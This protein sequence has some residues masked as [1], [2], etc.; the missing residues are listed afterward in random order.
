MSGSL[1]PSSGVNPQIAL[2]GQPVRSNPLAI[3]QQAAGAVG[4]MSQAQQAQ[5]TLQAQRQ[6]GNATLG[7][8]GEDGRFDQQRFLQSIRDNPMAGFLAPQALQQAR[9]AELGQ[10]QVAQGQVQVGMMRLNSLSQVVT[11]L[12]ENPNVSRRDVIDSVGRLLALPESERP[13]SATIAAGFLSNLPEDSAG[14]RQRLM[15]IAGSVRENQARLNDFL[16]RPQVLNFGNEQ[17]TIDLNPRTGQ[18]VVGPQGENF[19][20]PEFTNQPVQ[21]VGPQGETRVGPLQRTLPITGGLGTPVPSQAPAGQPPSGPSGAGRSPPTTGPRVNDI[22][23]SGR[24]PGG[25]GGTQPGPRVPSGGVGPSADGTV[26]TSLPPGRSQAMQAEA[27]RGQEMASVLSQAAAAAPN[28]IANL[29]TMRGLLRQFPTGGPVA[30][31]LRQLT[32]SMNAMLP[33]NLRVRPS[34]TAYQ[35]E[36]V[37]L[38]ERLAQEQ[39]RAFAGSAAASNMELESARAA[40]PSER[41]SNLGND[42]IISHLLGNEQAIAVK[43]RAWQAWRDRNGAESYTQ[44]E[45]AFNRNFDPR[46]FHSMFMAPEERSRMVNA[47]SPG[48]RSRFESAARHAIRE[49]WVTPEDLGIRRRQQ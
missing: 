24:Y 14:I 4:A 19:P 30:P 44:F 48:D 2:S 28:N 13:F 11:G 46:V 33:E 31:L 12:L 15:Q 27:V 37:K 5:E 1:Q 35:E 45:T 25:E 22:V 41:I 40:S 23:G 32:T 49:G 43:D 36:F 39:R 38:A 10:L 16:P 42:R 20:S 8:I 7:A 17:R 47:M 26:P 34:G 6:I 3:F 9:A 29:Q 21:Q 18:G